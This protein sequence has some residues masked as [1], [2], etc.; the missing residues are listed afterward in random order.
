MSVGLANILVFSLV[1]LIYLHIV[2]QR[3]VHNDNE[4]NILEINNTETLTEVCELRVPF[5]FRRDLQRMRSSGLTHDGILDI[6]DI[7]TVRV[8]D[9][10]GD[11]ATS[12][13]K[14]W[15]VFSA[16]MK[17]G[18]H[19]V[20]CEN[21]DW[22][23]KLGSIQPL[24]E[25]YDDFWK[26][27]MNVCSAN[28]I[29]IGSSGTKTQFRQSTHGRQYI[30]C[31]DGRVNVSLLPSDVTNCSVTTDGDDR[32]LKEY[33]TDKGMNVLTVT[34]EVGQVLCVP[35]YWWRSLVFGES[36]LIMVSKYRSLANY[37]ANIDTIGLT[38][39]RRLN[40]QKRIAGPSALDNKQGSIAE[41]VLSGVEHVE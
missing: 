33:D 34:L 28:T 5:V 15:N 20:V 16:S 30:T 24:V 3:R 23:L 7:A 9:I 12:S 26:P 41:S 18:E 19:R 17:N 1:L 29:A 6:E 38:L 13:S 39:L 14:P 4:V 32:V 22:P 37:L 35:P 31:L 40:T 2:H 11:V 27:Y 25:R 21:V 36:S 10:S 8:L